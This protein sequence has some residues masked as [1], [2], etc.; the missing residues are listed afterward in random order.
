MRNRRLQVHN[1]S[2]E[3]ISEAWAYL[4]R[5]PSPD[6]PQP[7]LPPHLK[8]LSPL[9]WH[10]LHHLLQQEL[11]EAL[12][13]GAPDAEIEQLAASIVAKPRAA[14]ASGFVDRRLR[15]RQHVG[16]QSVAEL[17][18]DGIDPQRGGQL[19]PGVGIL[20][21][22]PSATEHGDERPL[23]AQAVVV[24]RAGDELLAGDRKSVV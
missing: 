11:Q 5:L 21:R 4:A 10:L 7:L 18:V 6:L 8:D 17:G 16:R 14:I 15:I 2:L 3:E 23:P 12:A 13:K 24:Y 20:V 1:L 9:D 19:G 22:S